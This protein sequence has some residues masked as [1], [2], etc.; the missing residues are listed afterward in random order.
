[1]SP[2]LTY[3]SLVIILGT[4][5]QNPDLDPE[6][7]RELAPKKTMQC[8]ED[9]CV[10]DWMQHGRVKRRRPFGDLVADATGVNY[11]VSGER[12]VPDY[13][14]IGCRKVEIFLI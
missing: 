9:G 11:A 14:A 10:T 4:C 7:T 3:G 12:Q 1:M 13:R 6:R 5:K 2:K 8:P